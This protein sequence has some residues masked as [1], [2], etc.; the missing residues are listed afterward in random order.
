MNPDL[1]NAE[2]CTVYELLEKHIFNF[3]G[4]RINARLDGVQVRRGRYHDRGRGVRGCLPRPHALR[5]PVQVGLHRLW[6]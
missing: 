3:S 4:R 1:Y 6:R 2:S 5:F